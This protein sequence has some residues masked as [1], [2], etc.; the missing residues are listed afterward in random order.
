MGKCT[1]EAGLRGS[2]RGYNKHTCKGVRLQPSG[3]YKTRTSLRFFP[4][5]LRL[6]VGRKQQKQWEWGRGI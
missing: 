1:E 5:S 4:T 6:A 3:K 2:V